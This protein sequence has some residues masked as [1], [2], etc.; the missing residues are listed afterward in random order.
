M[1]NYKLVLVLVLGVAAVGGVFAQAKPAGTAPAVKNAVSLDVVPL[2]KGFI[3]S[4]EAKDGN[5]A[6]TVFGLAADYEYLI[7]PHYSIGARIDFYSMTHD[8]LVGTYFGLAVQGRW[9]ALS[10]SFEKFYLGTDIGFSAT[11][12]TNDGD[13][14]DGAKTSG[15]TFALKAGWKQQLGKIFIEPSLAYVYAK[16]VNISTYTGGTGTTPTPIGWQPGL[17]IGIKF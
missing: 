8:K 10:E 9:Y 7:A 15:F 3:A 5:K 12:A 6:T 4:E 1:K 2:F 17:N 16:T 13:A 14:V 11:S